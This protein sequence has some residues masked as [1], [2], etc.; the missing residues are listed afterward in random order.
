MAEN[1]IFV[2]GGVMSSLGK[3]IVTASIAA[4]LEDM[5]F[6]VNVVKLDPYINVD[7]G[8][9]NP[10]QHGEVYVTEDGAETDLD[11][12]HYE[13]FLSIQ[14]SR[15]NNVTTGKIYYS[16]IEKERRGEFLGST[17]QVIPHITDEI[18]E[19]I[20]KTGEGKDI[21]V[22]EVGG[23]V[24]DIESLPFLEA[25]RQMKKEK[26]TCYVHVTY[27]PI[28]E[29]TS[30]EFKTKPTQH[31]VM[32]L[33]EIGIQPDIII[34]R[35]EKFLPNDIIKKISLFCDVSED[36]VISDPDI[37]NIYELPLIF[38][39]QNLHKIISKK[40]FGTEP[41]SL[42]DMVPKE[43]KMEKW[44]KIKSIIN[45]PKG[46]LKIAI[47]GKYTSHQDAYLSLKEAIK[48]GGIANKLKINIQLI[49]SEE[50]EKKKNP[51]EVINGFDGVVI[52]GGFG[53]RGI[54]GKILSIKF[55]REN[56][57]PI[58]GICLG[59]QLMVVEFARNVCGLKGAHSSEFNPDTVYPVVD[60][61]E[62]QRKITKLGGTMRLG[63]WEVKI[64]GGKALQI[65]KTD[66]I[67]ERHRHRYEI[68]HKFIKIFEEKGILFSGI[69][70]IGDV[71]IPEIIEI[72]NHRWFIGTQ[73]HPEFKSKPFAPHPLFVSFIEASY[74]YK[75]ERINN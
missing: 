22:V 17:V 52:A 29:K 5:G 9:M 41:V 72:T 26:R 40:L 53:K 64:L 75:M 7:A 2:T 3:G 43:P 55:C 11:L 10:F 56:N 46:E 73:F 6:S 58:L 12:G 21:V 30:G 65:Y 51:E 47:V 23:T 57:I 38:R 48:H 36:A 32:K 44:E 59:A 25:I 68:S 4:I 28:L 8:T 34:C 70:S 14:M 45:N 19:H 16:V 50:I 61:L 18:K 1:F 33:R 49:D 66:K 60:L 54:E 37:E 69:S 42:F 20:K 35:S 71:P 24:G 15:M 13:R 31:S 27:V 62:E 74:K 39:D 67:Y 63:A